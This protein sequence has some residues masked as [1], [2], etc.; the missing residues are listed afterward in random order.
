MRREWQHAQS[1]IA[2]TAPRT[3]EV[4]VSFVEGGGESPR[5]ATK[6]ANGVNREYDAEGCGGVQSGDGKLGQASLTDHPSNG[7]RRESD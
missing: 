4:V 7:C 1:R 3:H 2:T 6:T 5:V